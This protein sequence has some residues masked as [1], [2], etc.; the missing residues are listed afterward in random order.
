MTQFGVSYFGNRFLNHAKE[1]LKR[2]SACCDYIVH[3][4]NETDLVY[5]KS[6]LSKLFEESR[7]VGLE[8]WVDPWGLG[9]VFG[10]E[11]SS[12]FLLEHRKS[13]QVMSNGK[14]VPS[15][16]LNRPEWRSFMKEWILSVRDM[17]GQ[18]IFWDEPHVAF[19]FEME[20]Q[21]IF[22]CACEECQRLYKNKYGEKMPERLND[23]AREFRRETM[24]SF[25][26]EGMAFSHSKGLKNSLCLYALK[27]HE[28]YDLLFKEAATLPD[29]DIFGC[30][31]YWHWRFKKPVVS[32]VE[33]FSKYV[34][35]HAT[36]NKKM[37]QIWIQAM[38]LPSGKESE[39]GL[40]VEAAIRQGI[41][42]IAAWSF[43]GGE[44]L[45]T[46]LSERPDMVWAETER[47]FLRFRQ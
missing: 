37:S 44:L 6:V 46:V 21:G 22:S 2:I 5:H 34:S 43:D 36:T 3:T 17:G 30:D 40:A 14:F 42:H 33:E 7:R 24:R 29:L 13:W 4:V 9:G 1:D 15:V 39:I 35:L 12:Q 16:C 31:P 47:A 20:W 32:H 19:D 45:D 41:S 23:Q 25:L 27:G 28:E 8:V 26:T 11:A 18:V 38:R 10:G